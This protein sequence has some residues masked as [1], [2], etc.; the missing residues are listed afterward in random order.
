MELILT[1][2]GNTFNPEDPV[3]W[4]GA[5]N[6]LPLVQKG[7]LQAEK[8]STRLLQQ[9]KVPQAV[10]CGPLQRTFSYASVI[11]ERL[12][13]PYRPIVD[14]RLNE[15]DYGGW[16]GLTQSE[17]IAQFGEAALKDWDERS[18]WPSHGNWGSSEAHIISE[19]KDFVHDLLGR[20]SKDET[21]VVVSSNGRLRYFLSLI[22]GEFEKR[23]KAGQFKV[24]TGHIC[25]LKLNGEKVS[26]IYWN[27]DP[28][29]EIEI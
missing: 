6:D 21:V 3:V 7:I 24:K 2:H 11:V 5:T 22:E 27:V 28:S 25:K 9:K 16:T 29:A 4:T 20:F 23:S 18:Q 14:P 17:V 10:Y 19:V 8:F 26:L 12:D 15:I 1:R 13:L